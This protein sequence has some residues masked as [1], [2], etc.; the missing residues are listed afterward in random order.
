MKPPCSPWLRGA[1]F[2][3]LAL[4][5]LVIVA[6]TPALEAQVRVAS[7]D[8]RYVYVTT[9]RGG[10]LLR[11]DAAS[12]MVAGSLAVGERPW[13]VAISPDGRMIVTANGTSN[14]ISIVDAANWTVAGRVRVGERPWGAV[15]L[16]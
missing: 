15:F 7:P 8:R 13:G 10:T 1:Q 2:I 12:C 6:S 5:A 9:G 3:C 11:I 16:R 14:D 4:A